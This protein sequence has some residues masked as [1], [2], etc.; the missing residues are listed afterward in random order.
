M[1][2]VEGGDVSR[3]AFQVAYHGVNADDHSMD[4]EALAPALLAFGKLIREANEQI[5]GD[6][7]KVK[8][9]VASDFEHKCFNINFELVQ[10][11]VQAIKDFLD[12]DTLKTAIDLLKALGVIGGGGSVGLI[13]FLKIKKGRKVINIQ[14]STDTDRSGDVIVNIKIEGENNSV[15]ITNDVLKLSEN[16][17][18]LQTINETLGPIETGNSDRIEFRDADK[19]IAS[20]D[21]NDVR[22]IVASCEAGSDDLIALDEAAPK[23]EI[24]IATLYVYSPVFDAKAKSWRFNYRRK[25]IYADISKTNIAKDALKRGGSFTNDRYRVRMEVTPPDVDGGDTHYKIIEVLDFSPAD[26]QAALALPKP[27]RKAAKRR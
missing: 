20:Y 9:L 1:A 22:S 14:K 8:V 12:D 17:K 25:H 13:A 27:K 16:R 21:R 5:N 6:R 18:I 23:P 19:P 2:E 11:I 3:H 7:A 15:Q 26:Q 4:V 24:V 10:T